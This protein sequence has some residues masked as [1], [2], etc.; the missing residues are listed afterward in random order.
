MRTETIVKEIFE[1]DEL[2]DSAKEKARDWYR[3]C[4]DTYDFDGPV[5]YMKEVCKLIGVDLKTDAYGH[6]PALYWSGFSSQGDGACFEGSYSY[7]KGSVKAIQAYAPHDDTLRRIARELQKLQ[8]RYFYSLSALV[9]HSGR[10]CHAG[11]TRVEVT[12]RR[13]EYRGID[14][15]DENELIELLRDL[16]HWFYKQLNQEND[17]LYSAECVDENIRCNEYEFDGLGNRF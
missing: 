14:A 7:T 12:D 13:D 5:E 17:W 3:G 4:I 1:F 2:D 10:Y 11:C 6:R 15:V 8:A 16:M 9:V